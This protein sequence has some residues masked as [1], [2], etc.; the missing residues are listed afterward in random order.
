MKIVSHPTSSEPIGEIQSDSLIIQNSED[1]SDVVGTAYFNG[2]D[3]V[4]L[5]QVNIAPAF[6]DL[7][8]GIAGEIFQKFANHRMRIVIVGDFDTLIANS[9]SLRDFIYES[10]SGKQV[11]FVPTLDEAITLLRS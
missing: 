11:N 7:R 10:N 8:N 3:K 4:I 9:K 6:F 1:G 5:H 2:F